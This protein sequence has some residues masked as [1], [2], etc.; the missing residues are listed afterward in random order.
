LEGV[1]FGWAIAGQAKELG[2]WDAYRRAWKAGSRLAQ[3]VQKPQ[4]DRTGSGSDKSS[5]NP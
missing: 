2:A 1:D 5:K 3:P 4:L